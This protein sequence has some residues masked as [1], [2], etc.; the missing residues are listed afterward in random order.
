MTGIGAH[1]P[2]TTEDRLAIHE[3]MALYGFIL[4]ERLWDRLDRL[5]TPD[6]VYD[7]TAFGVA[8]MHGI[9]DVRRAWSDLSIHPIAHHATNVVIFPGDDGLA[10]VASKGLGIDRKGRAHT[11]AYHDRLARTEHGWRIAQRTAILLRD[12]I[13]RDPLSF[14]ALTQWD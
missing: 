5:F 11:I 4:D 2:L 14:L 3:L 6:V 7:A 13:E 1:A 10:R 12:G 9:E 8:P